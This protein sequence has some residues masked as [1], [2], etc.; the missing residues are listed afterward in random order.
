[1]AGFYHMSNNPLQRY[2]RQP[3]IYITL[4]SGGKYFPSGTLDL[5]PN[6]ELPVYP[7]TAMDEITYRTADALFNGSAIVNVIKSC[8]P[9]IL[10]PWQLPSSDIDAVLVAM[11][12]ASY[13]H[14][15][16]FESQCP[17]CSEENDFV[18]DLREI[19]AQIK[20]P[21]FEETVVNGD[22]EVYF[23]PLN[24]QQS[25]E[26]AIKQFE[27][28]KILQSIPDADMP[29]QE[30]MDLINGALLK[31]GE[32]SVKSI[33]NSISTIRAGTDIVD[34][35]QHLTEFVKNCDRT[36]YGLLRDKLLQ[37]REQASVKP[38][39]ISCGKCN[40]AYET[41]FTLDVSNFFGPGS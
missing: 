17:E 11:R 9:N 14:E 25:N 29:D 6:G 23:K 37:L 35:P 3:A 16:E 2:F 24:Y 38:V 27:D 40:H 20:M 1:M 12:I 13:G 22:I 8:V 34:N 32:M 5:P 41:P 15:L 18:L 31:L 21:K 19:M 30:K 10:D 4:P 33:V 26:N 39:N 36:M 7:M 28:Q